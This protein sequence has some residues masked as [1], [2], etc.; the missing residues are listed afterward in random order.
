[1]WAHPGKQLLFM[2]CELADD[3]EWSEARGLDW[4]LLDDPQRA[5]VQSLVRDLNAAYKATPALWER[6]TAPEGF[7]WLHADDAAG[8]AL[9]FVRYS[10]DGSP[11]VCVVNFAAMPHENYRIGMPMAGRWR[12]MLNTDAGEYGGSGVGNMGAVYADDRPWH[13]Q[14]AS[15][16]IRVPPLGAIWLRPA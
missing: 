16:S 5:G 3:R 4:G 6:D 10:A 1:M 13:G 9:S 12:E 15:A 7:R 11:L 14:P 8:N 2:G